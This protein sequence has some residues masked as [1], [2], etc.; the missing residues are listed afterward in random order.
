MGKEFILPVLHLL[1]FNLFFL[2][3]VFNFTSFQSTVLKNDSI[4]PSLG[5]VFCKKKKKHILL[6]PIICADF[7]SLLKHIDETPHLPES[8][9]GVFTFL[10][11]FIQKQHLSEVFLDA[12]PCSCVLNGS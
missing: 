5:L 7:I 4:I 9:K 11:H 12:A 1:L 3:L 6:K 10:I 2:K 8:L